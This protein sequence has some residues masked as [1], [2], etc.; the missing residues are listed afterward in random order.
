MKKGFDFNRQK[1]S[2]I[3]I[4]FHQRTEKKPVPLTKTVAFSLSAKQQWKKQNA[5]MIMIKDELMWQR[6][7]E[8]NCECSKGVV[9]GKSI[10][11]IKNSYALVKSEHRSENKS[12]K[13]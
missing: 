1:R 2:R 13:K 12:Q 10:E 6:E 5:D 4:V 7:E 3:F 11:W 9:I 8:K